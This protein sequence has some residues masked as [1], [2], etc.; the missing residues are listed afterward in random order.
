MEKKQKQ[1]EL[2][3]T[4]IHLEMSGNQLKVCLEGCI[5]DWFIL[6]EK[7]ADTSPEFKKA[8]QLTA[9]FFE[10]EKQQND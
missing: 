8:I 1:N 9:D 2:K 5:K 4:K 10:F 7:T 6:L 3:T